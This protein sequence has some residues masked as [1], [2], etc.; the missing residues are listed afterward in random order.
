MSLFHWHRGVLVFGLG[1]NTKGREE[2]EAPKKV[3]ISPANPNDKIALDS[4]NQL[5]RSYSEIRKAR[6]N[7]MHPAVYV[8]PSSGQNNDPGAGQNMQGKQDQTGTDYPTR[9]GNGN[10]STVYSG[11]NNSNY[12]AVPGSENPKKKLE[13]DAA[14]SSIFF[15]SSS[16]K[17]MTATQQ[18]NQ[19]ASNYANGMAPFNATMAQLQGAGAQL[20]AGASETPDDRARQRAF[21]QDSQRPADEAIYLEHKIQTPRSPYQIMAGTI[22][23]SI[24][25]SGINSDLPGQIIAQVRENVYDTVTGKYLLIPQATKLIGTYDNQIVWGQDRVLQVWTRM[26]F[27]NGQSILLDGMQGVDTSGYSG[28]KDKVNNHYMRLAGAVLMSAFLSV[29]AKQAGDAAG[30]GDGYYPSVGRQIGEE[31]AGGVNKAGQRIVQ[32]ELNVAP[33]IEIRPG[34]KFNIMVNKDI[35]LKPYQR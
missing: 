7:T 29:G 30:D 18:Q 2:Q 17:P 31:V 25:I 21:L 19:Q 4:F 6:E 15:S 35:I 14:N 32:R 23:P 13:E 11:R 28:F 26:I 3:D 34:N 5:P 9:T 10:N 8:T 12:S 22:I 1:T 16:S 20:C 33:T 27:P 24:L